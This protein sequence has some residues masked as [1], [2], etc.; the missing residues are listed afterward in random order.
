MRTAALL[1]RDFQNEQDYRRH[2]ARS[3]CAHIVCHLQLRLSG[4][5]GYVD[6]LSV[7]YVR[8]DALIADTD[9]PGDRAIE[10]EGVTL[11][12]HLTVDFRKA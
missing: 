7:R 3:P 9:R 4:G 11:P 5:D 8:D 12:P 10:R 6:A 1:N 2:A